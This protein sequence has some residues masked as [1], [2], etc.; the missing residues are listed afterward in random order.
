MLIKI[1]KIAIKALVI[2]ALSLAFILLL[3]YFFLRKNI[4]FERDE[5]LF[6]LA[7][8]SSV[9]HFFADGSP[10][11]EELYEPIEVEVT[12]FG[13]AKKI[14]YSLSECSE[15]LKN[16]FV[17]VEDREFYTH[18]GVNL[19]RTFGAFLNY[20][21]G[22]GKQYGAST[23]TQQVVKNIS[24]DNEKTAL[25]KVSEI[26]R[27]TEIE[28]NHSKDEILEMYLNIVPMS[29]NMVGVGFASDRY[30]G[31]TPDTLSLSEAA[32]IVGITNSPAKYDPRKNPEACV[33]RRNKVLFAMLD[34]GFISEEDYENAKNS[35][36]TLI[37][38]DTAPRSW[39]VETVIDEL[40][41]DI[42]EAYDLS[43]SA[44]RLKLMRGGYNVYMTEKRCVQEKL[45]A[46][47]ENP[48]NLPRECADG[49]NFAMCVCDSKS[50]VLLGTIGGAGQKEGAELL[51]LAT[52]P[53]PPGSCLKPLALYAPLLDEGKINWATVFDDVPVSF[54]ETGGTVTPYPRNSPERY[55]GLI[56]VKDAL[57]L[58][59][60][61]VAIRLFELLGKEKIFTA[62]T[63]DFAFNTIVRSAKGYSGTVSDLAPSPLALGQLSFG[64]PLKSLTEA[65]TVFP[66]DGV[67]HS[68]R[69]YYLV[70]DKDGGLVIDKTDNENRIY[71]ESTARIM[72]QL[73]MSVVADGTA[74]RIT[75]KHEIDTAGKTGTT[76]E[77]RD[78][79][80]VG[81][82][83]YLTAGIWCGYP[84]S[85]APVS[86]LSVSH[87]EIW[88]KVM[89]QLHEGVN[90]DTH[91]KTDGLI[92]SEYC[93]DSGAIPD[94]SCTFDPRAD[95]IEYG[96]FTRD[97]A[98]REFCS[99][100]KTYAFDPISGTVVDGFGVNNLVPIALPVLPERNFPLEIEVTDEKYR[101]T[102]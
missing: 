5:E 39:F 64:I 54:S 34:M 101:I 53:H 79:L 36:L 59:K 40:I 81:Y 31:K 52:V 67:K 6:S 56:T 41:E 71:K 42:K 25:R 37:K 47:F 84:S 75:L 23:I 58:S 8:S 99:V 62:L 17:A 38:E 51:N 33:L 10:V 72:N 66:S 30:F 83:P 73:L 26:L 9:T 76:A 63:E 78:R 55:D 11:G 45:E 16:G 87:L 22:G 70:C 13:A 46:F 32:A 80:F 68:S 44:A 57:R 3:S 93:R 89:A 28:K 7:K 21:F 65:Y 85:N 97:N 35:P 15:Y 14:W 90:T 69:S 95:R 86:T 96:Y 49:L 20:I 50:G 27:A 60:N 74:E 102:L 48:D 4:D 82:T 12:A 94:I 91:F 43:D 2:L 100:H 88:D 18:S 19:R 98:P 1:I 77:G 29:E 24:G 92:L 61:T